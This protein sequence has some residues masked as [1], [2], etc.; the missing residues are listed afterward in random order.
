[1]PPHVP[2]LHT[3][4][5]VHA[6]PSS[7]AGVP[8]TGRASQAPLVALQVPT[9]QVSVMPLQS[10]AVPPHVPE[11]HTSDVVQASPSLQEV[12]S[13]TTTASQ[14]PLVALQ[15]PT[16]QLLSMPLQSLAVPPQVPELQT[17]VI[18]QA[19]P[20][21]QL[22]VS[23]TGTASQAPL[24]ALQVPALQALSMP[25]Q[26]LAVLEQLPVSQVSTVHGSESSQS[27][28]LPQ[29]ASV[30]PSVAASVPP[31]VSAS[32]LPSIAASVPPS[33]APSMP[34]STVASLPPSPGPES[35]VASDPPSPILLR[36]KF[37]M[38]SQPA[39]RPIMSTSAESRF[40]ARLL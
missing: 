15:V 2:E 33:T 21:S 40:I 32:V 38:A 18:V 35:A 36:S 28:A 5:V 16:W 27:A 22:V 34:E 3:S 6:S 39:K 26:S 11:L 10:I 19:S 12:V 17:S 1:M 7:H 37:T 24:V 31:S 23:A 4:D 14:A 20:S 8:A 25:L 29:P 9:L 30:L 13:A